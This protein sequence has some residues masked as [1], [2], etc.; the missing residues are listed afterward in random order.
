ME[1]STFSL[2]SVPFSGP[3]RYDGWSAFR[4][5]SANRLY[6]KP[7]CSG[8]EPAFLFRGL[9]FLSTPCSLG[10]ISIHNTQ[11]MVSKQPSG[12][13]FSEQCVSSSC[14][15]RPAP[16]YALLS[17]GHSSSTT[18]Q[19]WPSKGCP[20]RC[21]HCLGPSWGQRSQGSERNV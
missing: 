11:Y 14:C 20:Q 12:E 1:P 13:P 18:S 16:L 5:Q 9:S 4:I 21:L 8:L 6:H 10:H 19:N 17:P 15:V 7:K 3:R 2:Q